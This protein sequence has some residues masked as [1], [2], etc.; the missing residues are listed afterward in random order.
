MQAT[1]KAETAL[2]LVI[3]ETLV[4]EM[5]DPMAPFR[6]AAKGKR[7]RKPATPKKVTTVDIVT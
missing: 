1:V 3:Y 4:A 2:P 6:V 5:G 7:R